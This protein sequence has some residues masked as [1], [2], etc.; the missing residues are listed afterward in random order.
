[1]VALRRFAVATF[2]AHRLIELPAVPLPCGESALV[3]GFLGSQCFA[4]HQPNP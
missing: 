1:M 3:A 4:F 2:L